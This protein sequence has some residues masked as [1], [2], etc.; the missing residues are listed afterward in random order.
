M[1][2]NVVVVGSSID[3]LIRRRSPPGDVC[4]YDVRTGKKLWTF[5]TIPHV[6]E[7]GVETWERESYNESGGANVWTSMT[8]D[9]ER[10]LV[11]LPI[12]TAT[13]DFY[14]GDRPGANLF[15]DTLVALRAT[16]GERVW[17]FQAVHHDLYDL[18]SPAVL[19][20]IEREGRL[21]DAVALPT[22]MGFVFVLDRETGEPLFPI[23]ERPVP[24]S[25][26]PGE[27]SSSTQ[28]F[29][30]RPPPLV[31]QRLDPD[32]VWA[33]SASHA[34]DCRARIAELRNEGIFTPPSLGGSILY[35]FHRR[36]CQ[37]VGSGFRSRAAPVDR[38]CQK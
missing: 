31:P 6:D 15:S 14:G 35:P 36:W 34:R 2:G 11:F 16:T 13:P 38:T 12:S 37:L 23:E 33:P 24:V 9:I 22:K 10:D 32:D 25:D 20:T 28:P 21:I 8:A 18:A 5:H 7:F 26:V 29:P 3:D 19:T 30:T 27:Q 4:G 1:V 17:H